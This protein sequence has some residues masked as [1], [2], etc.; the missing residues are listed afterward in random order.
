MR[1]ML[2]R[3]ELTLAAVL[4]GLMILAACDD[5]IN[6]IDDVGLTPAE[7]DARVLTQFSQVVDRLTDGEELRSRKG[8]AYTAAGGD[9]AHAFGG[10]YFG[11]TTSLNPVADDSAE[12]DSMCEGSGTLFATCVKSQMDA[13]RECRTRVQADGDGYYAYCEAVRH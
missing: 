1:R 7:N 8:P 6:L 11:L 5:P 2:K 3:T 9:Q 13:A 4:S 10:G 12:A